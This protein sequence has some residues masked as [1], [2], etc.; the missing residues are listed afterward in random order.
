MTTSLQITNTQTC[1]TCMETL[2]KDIACGLCRACAAARYQA[3]AHENAKAISAIGGRL[4]AVMH[5]RA[6]DFEYQLRVLEMQRLREFLDKPE[7]GVRPETS[8]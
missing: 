1:T 4:G 3:L 7:Q 2:Y 8:A 6:T 5:L